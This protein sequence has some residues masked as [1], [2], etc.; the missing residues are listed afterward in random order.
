MLCE[1]KTGYLLNFIIYT[2]ATAEYSVQPD[3]LPIKFDEYKNPSKVVLSLLHDYLHKGCC[4]TLDNYYTSLELANA[5]VSCGTDCYGTL[6]KK[7]PLPNQY[8]ERKTKKGDPPKSQFKDEV[9]VMRWNG[10]SKMKSVKFACMLSTIQ[11]IEMVDYNKMERST[12]AVI[13]KPD[14]IMDYNVTIDSVNLVS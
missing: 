13:Q 5:L 6:L 14:V 7:Q 2:G 11:T 1:S 3:P 12:G 8:W 4:V 9:G 10:A